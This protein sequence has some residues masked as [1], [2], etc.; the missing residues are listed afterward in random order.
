MAT[1]SLGG[2][3]RLVLEYRLLISSTM[4]VRSELQSLTIRDDL[5]EIVNVLTGRDK[6]TSQKI[7]NEI[8][9]LPMKILDN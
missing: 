4:L 5:V 7:T 1:A 9:I 6:V 3:P 2:V 8:L